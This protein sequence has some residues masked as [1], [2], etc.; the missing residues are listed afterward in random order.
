MVKYQG[1]GRVVVKTGCVKEADR[2]AVAGKEALVKKVLV[3]TAATSPGVLPLFHTVQAV[4]A[5]QGHDAIHMPN[6]SSKSQ[7]P[8]CP[9]SP[10]SPGSPDSPDSPVRSWCPPKVL[11][12]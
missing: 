4:Q 11:L 12:Q 9:D 7:C 6:G 8:R 1:Y 3:W 5:F 10:D 2:P